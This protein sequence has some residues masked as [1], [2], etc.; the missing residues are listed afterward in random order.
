MQ[1]NAPVAMLKAQYQVASSHTGFCCSK[2]KYKM[3]GVPPMQSKACLA[4]LE[5][6]F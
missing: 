4:M 2:V 3:A 5:M 1:S 6:Q